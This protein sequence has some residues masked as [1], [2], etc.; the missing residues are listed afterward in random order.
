M[1]I[2]F[3]P[4]AKHFKK[5]KHSNGFISVVEVSTKEVIKVEQVHVHKEYD[6]TNNGPKVTVIKKDGTEIKPS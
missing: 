2:I 3:G 5:T 4:N 6:N 1:P